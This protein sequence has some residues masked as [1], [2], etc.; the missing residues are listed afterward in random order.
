MKRW[1]QLDLFAPKEPS[2]VEIL[3]ALKALGELWPLARV[4]WPEVFSEV[5]R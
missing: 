1:Q 5:L 3:A 4:I 2:L